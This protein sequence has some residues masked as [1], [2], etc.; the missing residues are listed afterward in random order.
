MLKLDDKADITIL[1]QAFQNALQPVLDKYNLEKF[2]TQVTYGN[3]RME[4]KIVVNSKDDDAAE[5]AFSTLCHRYSIPA[6]KYKAIK[7][8]KGVNYQLLGFDTKARKYPCI[9]LDM[10]RNVKVK[11]SAS[12][13]QSN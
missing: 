9:V 7:Q 2:K 8:I 4:F 11:M 3:N 1:N 10:S 6:S 12:A 5:E 13:W